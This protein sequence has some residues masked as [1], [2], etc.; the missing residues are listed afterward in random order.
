MANDDYV[1]VHTLSDRF[2]ADLLMAALEQ[3]HIPAILR[4]FV[5]T[6]YTGLFVPQKGWGLVMVPAEM[7]SKANE[8]I[9]PL[10][11]DIRSSDPYPEAFEI[12]AALWDGLRAADPESICDNALVEYDPENDFYTVPFLGVPLRVFPEDEAVQAPEHIAYPGNDFELK[13]VLLHYLLEAEDIDFS[14]KWI[15]EKDIPSGETFFRGPHRLPID[16]LLRVFGSDLDLFQAASERLGGGAAELGDIAYR[17]WVLPRIPV[18]VILWEGDDEF[19]PAIHILFDGTV[20]S[21]L[22]ALDTIWA[23]ANVFCRTLLASARE[24]IEGEEQ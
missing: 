11:K 10:I 2:E 22:K 16:D 18:L 3:E 17:F 20:D 21:H 19:E 7:A 24:C 8:I 12:D 1:V 9:D 15:S 23:L 5:E 14:R 4:P 6:A 13:L